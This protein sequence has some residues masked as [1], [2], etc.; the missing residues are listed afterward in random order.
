MSPPNAIFPGQATTTYNQDDCTY[1]LTGPLVS[2]LDLFDQVSPKGTVLK[3]YLITST[4]LLKNPSSTFYTPATHISFSSSAPVKPSH[5]LS[6]RPSYVLCLLLGAFFPLLFFLVIFSRGWDLIF[7]GKPSVGRYFPSI[8]SLW[9]H[10]TRY[11]PIVGLIYF[12]LQLVSF[13]G[14]PLYIVTHLS[15]SHFVLSTK[16][17]RMW[18][19]KFSSSLSCDSSSLSF[20]LF[21]YLS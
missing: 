14:L 9:S 13:V 15:H 17:S 2:S 12:M 19:F 20:L 3:Q 16:C 10:R 7:Y 18:I 8:T 5:S 1:L 6:C 21:P 4:L 11:S